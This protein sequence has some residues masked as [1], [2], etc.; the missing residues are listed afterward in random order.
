MPEAAN[1]HRLSIP[2][3]DVNRRSDIR[4]E[5]AATRQGLPPEVARAL[6]GDYHAH[7][8]YSDGSGTV[9]E[10]VEQAIAVGLSEIGISDHISAVQP[11]PWKMP[12]IAFADLG[13]T[14]PRCET[15]AGSYER[16]HGAARHRGRLRCPNTKT[17]CVRGARRPAVRLRDRRRARWSTASISTTPPCAT[18]LAGT[19]STPLFTAYYDKVRRAAQFGKFDIIAHLDY[20]GLWGHTPGTRPSTRRSP[21]LST[22][23]PFGRRHRAEHRPHQ[24]PGRR[25]CTQATSCCAPR[26]SAA[27]RWC[28]APTPTAR[29]TSAGCGTRPW[30]APPGRAFAGSCASPTTPSCRWPTGRSAARRPGSLRK[31]RVQRPAGRSRRAALVRSAPRAARFGRRRRRPP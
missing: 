3:C 10:S 12:S 18:T 2:R 13:A 9:A 24:R 15:A 5:P 23:S 17:S 31:K 6:P 19:T 20:I 4:C 7:T 27:Y 8:T 29:R 16:G 11:S 21:R 22:P 26:A 1:G 28:W 14:S 25:R 30:G